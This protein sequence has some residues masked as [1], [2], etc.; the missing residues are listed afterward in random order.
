MS[1]VRGQQHREMLWAMM[2]TDTPCAACML[3][4]T[5]HPPRQPW[6]GSC[7]GLNCALQTDI[8]RSQPATAANVA[9]FGNKVLTEVIK[10]R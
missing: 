7:C 8:L 1:P 6:E 5:P 2:A 4:V 9:S 3:C 10:L